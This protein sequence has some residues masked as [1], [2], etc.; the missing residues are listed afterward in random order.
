MRMFIGSRI[1]IAL[2]LFFSIIT[3]GTTGYI[4]LEGYTVI[5]AFYMV[6]ISI[7]TVG[8]GEVKPLSDTGRVFTAI[9]ILIGIGSIGFIGTSIVESIFQRIWT[10]RAGLLKMK[11]NINRL[12]SHFIVCGF[13]RVGEAAVEEFE[14]QKASFV[15][16]EPNQ[17]RCDKMAA[18]GYMYIQGDATR[19]DAL[20]DAGIKSAK[21]L[22]AL[23]SS[24]PNNLFIALTG[25]ELNPTLRIIA[26][27]EEKSS[28]KRI[29]QAGAD[30]V[31]SPFHTAG[32]RI[33]DDILA[34]TGVL[35]TKPIDPA[36]SEITPQWITVQEGSSMIGQTIKKVSEEMGREIVGLRVL[37]NDC[38]YPKLDTII[39]DKDMLLVLT[40]KMNGEKAKATDEPTNPPKIVIIDDNIVIL[41]L[42]VRLFQKAGF[43]PVTATDGEQG[44]RLILEEKPVAAI[45]DYMLPLLSGIEICQEVRKYQE[46]KDIKLIL[47]TGDETGETKKKALKAGADEVV[48]KTPEAFE[49]IQAAIKLIKQEVS[50]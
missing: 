17:E 43:N 31:I 36:A 49:V 13:G 8:F 28:E 48:R 25:R 42:Y 33:A 37:N 35:K 20:L 4:F 41:R 15:V 2:T 23:L 11:K 7:T 1:F 10:G 40:E 34:N 50:H 26:R 27:G 47:F 38:I 6:I 21:G 30:R 5:E 44:L 22:L 12:K 16:I 18:K 19:E 32:R 29:L 45:I 46:L 24:D 39:K 14:K 3:I 9:M